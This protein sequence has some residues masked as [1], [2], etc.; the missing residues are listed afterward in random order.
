MDE[1]PRDLDDGLLLRW[2]TADDADELAAFNVRIHSDNP[3][4]PEVWL[5]HWTRDLL[6]GKHPTTAPED[7]TV[8][9]DPEG[10]IVSSVALISQTWEYAGIPVAVG[11][12][13]LVGTDAEH[14]RPGLC[15]VQME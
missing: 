8:V 13:E 1:L 12:P 14:R 4:E 2:A 3:K 11:Q 15:D 5:G 10:R 6:G 9:T 7:V